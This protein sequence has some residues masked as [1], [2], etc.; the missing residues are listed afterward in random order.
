ML[1]KCGTC[2]FFRE[3]NIAKMGFCTH[4]NRADIHDVVLVRKVELSCRNPWDDDLWRPA[5]GLTEEDDRAARSEAEVN[6]PHP[7]ELPQPGPVPEN[8]TDRVMEIGVQASTTRREMPSSKRA[9][10]GQAPRKK[11][12]QPDDE[13]SSDLR[14]GGQAERK[15]FSPPPA[16]E[17]VARPRNAPAYEAPS[18]RSA[19]YLDRSMPLDERGTGRDAGSRAARSP[20]PGASRA[21]NVVSGGSES[22]AAEAPSEQ[23]DVQSTEPLP[24][25]E[26]REQTKER[27]TWSNLGAYPGE[28]STFTPHVHVDNARFSEKEQ[29]QATGHEAPLEDPID[30]VAWAASIPRC[31]GTCRDF[32]RS[33][34]G[35]SGVCRNPYA[36]ADQR[37]R[38]V[39]SDQLACRWSGGV[40]WLPNDDDAWRGRID[41]SRHTRPTPHLD[42]AL[43]HPNERD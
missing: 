36:F 6:V 11:A 16:P 18:G 23:H 39:E 19:A 26:V 9:P 4:P 29:Y 40:F 14:T 1:R 15:R 5:E 33:G 34:D 32:R 10:S 2:Y 38:V 7:S 42:A 8:P 21:P 30:R 22:F 35:H 37:E 24:V 41:P 28:T 43:G 3:A 25:E 13:R 31:C 27:D 12:T 20:E 17:T